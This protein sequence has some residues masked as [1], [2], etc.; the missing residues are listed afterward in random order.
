MNCVKCICAGAF[1]VFASVPA[2]A[3]T[4]VN[5]GFE[6]GTTAGWSTGEGYRGGVDNAALTPSSVL[7]GG[8]LYDGPATR[9]GVV[10][11]GTVD[12]TIGASF[13]S[14]VYAG[15]NA[16]RIEDTSSGGYA[17]AISQKVTGYTDSTIIFAWKAVLENGGHDPADSAFFRIV[18]R[19]DTTG[20]DVISRTYDAGAEGG[21]VDSRF[22][23]LGD[24][25]YTS[26]WQIENLVIDSSLLGH[27]FT[28]ALLAADCLPTGHLGYAYLDGFGGSITN[29]PPIDP[30]PGGNPPPTGQV[31]LPGTLALLGL[32]MAS[33]SAARRR[34]AA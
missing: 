12:P 25:F 4:F 30:P 9:S 34:K 8:S 7:P 19:D 22:S 18:L 23:A 26:Q 33:L 16:Y 13:G 1:A 29:P 3:A 11:A 24:Y 21:G 17:S 10:S 32:G 28:L 15:N 31:P 14:T 20:R 2:A 27:D 5:G 6:T